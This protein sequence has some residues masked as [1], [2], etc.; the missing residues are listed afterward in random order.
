MK[1]V[2]NKKIILKKKWENKKK[3]INEIKRLFFNN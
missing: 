1:K 2:S 3:I